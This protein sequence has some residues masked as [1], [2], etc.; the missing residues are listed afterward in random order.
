MSTRPVI[1]SVE[2]ALVRGVKIQTVP[3]INEETGRCLQELQLLADMHNIDVDEDV[4]KWEVD[5]Q[6][7]LDRIVLIQYKE[8]PIIDLD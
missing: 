3:A 5:R 2:D 4:W 8:L 7:K 1:E 6:L